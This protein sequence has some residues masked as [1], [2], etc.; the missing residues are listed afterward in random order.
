[1]K[2]PI[3]GYPQHRRNWDTPKPEIPP[4]P[5]TPTLPTTNT[6]WFALAP[7]W[8]IGILLIAPLF[9]GAAGVKTIIDSFSAPK[10]AT[11]EQAEDIRADVKQLKKDFDAR[12]RARKSWEE[13]QSRRD[14]I[15][16]EGL[17]KLN[18]GKP[19]AREAPCNELIWNTPP[20][21]A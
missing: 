13:R 17:C 2:T 15:L 1:M 21:E 8:A 11:T 14:Q 20:L 9:G 6:S 19:I 5:K 3:P 7:K 10:P 18:G 4:P 16:V 12:E